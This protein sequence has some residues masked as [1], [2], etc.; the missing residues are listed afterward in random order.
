MRTV[1]TGEVQPGFTLIEL[2]TVIAIIGVL[3]AVVGPRFASTSTYDERVFHDDVLQA[4]RFAQARA[5]GSGCMTRVAFSAT[6]FTVERDDCNSSNGFTASAVINPDGL[7]SGYTQLDAPPA[8]VTYSYSVNPLVF[9][10]EGR[11][12]N[13]SLSILS[14]AAQVTVGS[15][16]IRV[17]GATGYVH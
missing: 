14:S 2:I 7:S 12:R 1:A 5:V 4:L 13:G 3:A 8:G 16:T 15:R 10:P 6:G 17:E 11:A 9:D